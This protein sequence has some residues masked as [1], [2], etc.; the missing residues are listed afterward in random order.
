MTYIIHSKTHITAEFCTHKTCKHM[1]WLSFR[2]VEIY[3]LYTLKRAQTGIQ[4]HT[5]DIALREHM[6]ETDTLDT[7]KHT[8]YE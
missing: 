1:P 6:K 5:Y 7:Y 3:A 2:I 4:L 8:H